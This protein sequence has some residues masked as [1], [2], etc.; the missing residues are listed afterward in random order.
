MDR[1][2]NDGDVVAITMRET[3]TNGGLA[4]AEYGRGELLPPPPPDGARG[5]ARGGVVD[6]SRGGRG[7]GRGVGEAGEV[8]DEL[9]S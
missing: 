4:P 2:L 7:G 8:D 1:A 9:G 3:S 6:G 5:G